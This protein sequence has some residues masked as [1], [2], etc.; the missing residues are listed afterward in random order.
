MRRA[1][2]ALVESLRGQLLIA[3]PALGDYFHRAVVLMIEHTGEGA[4]GV[5]VNRPS[6]VLVADALPQL[7]ELAEPDEVIYLG[8]PVSRDSVIAV[9]DF[10]DP[11]QAARLV[12]GDVGLIDPDVADPELR[13]MRAFAGYAGWGPG[14]LESELEEDAWIVEPA[15]P[16]DAFLGDQA[17]PAVLARKGGAYTLLARMPAD[18]SLN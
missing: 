2:F 3:A 7:A 6:E 10:E 9:G 1:E 14:Q 13:A 8:G 4:M 11:S 12:V 17:W 15:Q 18:P 5:V 16:E